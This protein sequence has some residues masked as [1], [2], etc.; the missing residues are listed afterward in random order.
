MA[1]LR[2]APPSVSTIYG[3]LATLKIQQERQD[4]TKTTRMRTPTPNN[5]QSRARSGS[6][7]SQLASGLRTPPLPP[8][9]Q[10]DI[11]FF[12]PHTRA[13]QHNKSTSNNNGTGTLSHNNHHYHDPNP[14]FTPV[15]VTTCT[16]HRIRRPILIH[17]PKLVMST[18]H[19][20]DVETKAELTLDTH[21]RL[22]RRRAPRM[23]SAPRIALSAT[24]ERRRGHDST[25]GLK[26][27]TLSP[28]TFHEH[29]SQFYS[30]RENT[31]FFSS[32]C[33]N[34]PRGVFVLRR[35]KQ[36]SIPLRKVG[37]DTTSSQN[38]CNLRS[39][40]L[41]TFADMLAFCITRSCTLCSF[42]TVY[43]PVFGVQ[44]T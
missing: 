31:P 41:N 16:C 9:S 17:H 19:W 20:A 11:S 29:T 43:L 4:A 40:V 15:F 1:H 10:V 36:S 3:P 6:T 5:A 34:N 18:A 7:R 8:R 21:L 14:G 22:Q 28:T 37:R 27:S 26:T 23:G 13:P 32:A 30:P 35:A 33:S 2:S 44:V 42:E 25:L 39:S 12:H 24:E 38:H